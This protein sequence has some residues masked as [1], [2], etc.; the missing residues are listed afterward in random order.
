MKDSTQFLKNTL[1]VYESKI[2]NKEN[3]L[4]S[5]NIND[6]SKS[7]VI[8]IVEGNMSLQVRILYYYLLQPLK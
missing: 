5:N 7:K 6:S 2:E 1:S 3:A 8:H 4:D